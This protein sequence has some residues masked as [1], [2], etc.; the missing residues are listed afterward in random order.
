MKIVNRIEMFPIGELKPIERNPNVHPEEQIQKF[1]AGINEYGFLVPLLV[2]DAREIIAG[3]GRFLAAQRIGLTE[4]PGIV[5]DHLTSTQ[6]K[7]F[8]IFDK[9]LC[10]TPWNTGLLTELLAEIEGDGGNMDALGFNEGELSRMLDELV[11][12]G[13]LQDGCG[14][15]PTRIEVDEA[16]TQA[17]IGEY[18]FVIPREKYLFWIE[19]LRQTVGF[20]KQSVIDELRR[21]LEL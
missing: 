12:P 17:T 9:K 15:S 20:D 14:S 4:I 11:N 10:E 16:D 1:I 21:R 2:N 5:V 18:R 3:E 7:A 6:V 19:E 13:Q 8:R